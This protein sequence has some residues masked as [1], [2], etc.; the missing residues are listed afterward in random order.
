MLLFK[1]VCK[2]DWAFAMRV[3]YHNFVL[4][5]TFMPREEGF[6]GDG[7]HLKDSCDF[8]HKNLLERRYLCPGKKVLLETGQVLI[9][10]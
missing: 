6:A 7:T 9:G 2:T 4:K 3:S 10:V 5:K 1:G 8:G